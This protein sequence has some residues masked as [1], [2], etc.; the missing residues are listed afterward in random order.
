MSIEHLGWASCDASELS[1]AI[2]D[3]LDAVSWEPVDVPEGPFPLGKSQGYVASVIGDFYS[4][5]WRFESALYLVGHHKYADG[6]IPAFSGGF[7]A[8]GDALVAAVGNKLLSLTAEDTTEMGVLE[9]PSGCI[10]FIDPFA[11]DPPAT[12]QQVRDVV[13]SGK[14]A[15][16]GDALFVPV[17]AGSYLLTIEELDHRDN[18]LGTF[19]AR[20]KLAPR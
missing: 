11:G 16:L 15:T 18:D 17:P 12:E 3:G 13:S 19:N 10:A 5:V 6:D 7:K 4:P 20:I 8:W 14:P 1:L 9:V 2:V